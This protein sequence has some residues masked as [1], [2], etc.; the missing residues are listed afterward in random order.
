MNNIKIKTK[1]DYK[2]MKYLNLYLMK[3][4]RKTVLLY[5]VLIVM[6]LGAGTYLFLSSLGS[7]TGPNY[8]W[9]VLFG[10]IALYTVYQLLSIEKSLDKHLK[11][12]FQTKPLLEVTIELNEENV[13][14]TISTRPNEAQKYDWAFVQAID[15]IPGYYFLFMNNNTP[16]VLD[17]SEDA[18]L[19]GSFEDLAALIKEKC[20]T[21]PYKFVNKEIVKHPIPEI[22]YIEAVLTEASSNATEAEVVSSDEVKEI[23]EAEEKVEVVEEVVATEEAQEENK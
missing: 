10:V 19:E 14:E 6:A 8:L 12:Y 15:E 16:I 5:I 2:T 13:I 20:E 21:K 7:E 22:A 9:P 3:Y 23:E 1:Y 4:K 18:L 11:N 17:K